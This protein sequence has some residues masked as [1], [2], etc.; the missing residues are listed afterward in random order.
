MGHVV[1]GPYQTEHFDMINN[2]VREVKTC[3]QR[4]LVG[5]FVLST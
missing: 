5:P 2:S 4:F 3:E 1:G